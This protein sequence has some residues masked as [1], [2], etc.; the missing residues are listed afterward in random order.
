MSHIL[1]V[2]DNVRE[3]ERL[4]RLFSDDGYLVTAVS[5]A[6]EAEKELVSNRFFLVFLDISLSDKSGTYL[7]DLIKATTPS[8]HIVIQTGNPSVHLKQRFLEQGVSAYI[9]KA[10]PEAKGE[11]ILAIVRRLQLEPQTEKLGREYG[12]ELQ[13]FL[14][15][16]LP[17]ESHGL[18]LSSDRKPSACTSCGSREYMVKFSDAELLP[19]SVHGKITC[20]KCGALYPELL[21]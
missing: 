9:V 16:C 2:E 5:S 19:P 14:D 7:V 4:C 21:E 11:E 12:I 15:K 13:V 6:Q 20:K 1:V 3:S 17:S 10:T 8:P 18:I